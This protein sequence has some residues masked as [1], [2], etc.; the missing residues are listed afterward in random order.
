MRLCPPR[1]A[2]VFLLAAFGFS[3]APVLA[4]DT[5]TA[6]AASA[7]QGLSPVAHKTLANGLQVLVA[8]SGNA[9]LVT[10]DAWVGA[11]TRRETAENNGAAHFIEHLL[12]K[13]TPTRQPGEIDAAIEDLGGS[14]NAATSYDWAHFYVTVGASDA[15]PALDILS[16]V[17][18]HAELRQQDMDQERPVI[19]SEMARQLADPA[20]RIARMLNAITFPTHP[21]GRP[22][23][24]PP[25][26][27]TSMT[28]KT[29]QDF[30]HA[31]YAPGNVTLVLTGKI[32]PEQG[33]A[34]A[35]KAFGKWPERPI[36]DDKVLSEPKQT[37][38]RTRAMNAPVS[39][40]YLTI[41][42]RAPSVRDHAT[43]YAMDVLLTILGQGGHNRLKDDLQDKQKLLTGVSA[44]YLT[45]K[46]EGLMT[47]T[48]IFE[49]GNRDE[50]LK[51]ILGEIDSLRTKPVSEKELAA[52]KHSLL[53]SYLFD[54]Q[55]T[56]GRANALGFY[57]MIDS[58]Q[59]DTAYITQFEKLTPADVQNVAVRYLDPE[60]YSLVTLLPVTD[61]ATATSDAGSESIPAQRLHGDSNTA[62]QRPETTSTDASR[63]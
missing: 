3:T 21:Y 56:S 51:A 6:P 5:D 17:L 26:H 44:N 49:P 15:P 18:M 8:P 16:D 9:D 25:A 37:E 58:Y 60:K 33:F 57:N 39:K 38:I 11:G 45:Q 7:A 59:Y 4:A 2:L 43:A 23:L 42:F 27:I 54:V 28:R 20:Q 34:M 12:F 29:V 53:A 14:M 48:A 10:L 47:I 61:P 31:Y 19:L 24:G 30:Y 1:P 41:G 40:G 22:L 55:T 35:E 32:T 46:D 52:A 62:A 63:L 50:A 36:P 13:G